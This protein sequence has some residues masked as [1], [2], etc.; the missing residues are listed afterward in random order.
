MEIDQLR[1]LHARAT[2]VVVEIVDGV[3]GFDDAALGVPTPCAAWD[4]AALLAHMTGQD[5]G[6][7]AATTHDADAAA[8]R[9]GDP[10]PAAH[11]SAAL[12]LVD[13]FAAADP[14]RP[15]RLAEFGRRVPLAAAVGFHLVDTLVHGWDVAASVGTEVTY[16]DDLVAA[17]LVLAEQVPAGA[18]R[19]EPGAAFA[20]RLAIPADAGAWHRTLLL[21][22]RDPAWAPP[23]P[24]A[25]ADVSG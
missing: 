12:A 24:P 21:L 19:E 5:L 17:G 4:L 7:A 6:F 22:G 3:D 9:P 1:A 10:S 20:P 8:Y 2:D 13:A 11:R 18:A 15:V 14:A 16:D 23:P 25:R